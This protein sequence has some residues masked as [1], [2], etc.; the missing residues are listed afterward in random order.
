[1]RTW[2]YHS[3]RRGNSGS[4]IVNAA[5]LASVSSPESNK[6][7]YQRDPKRGKETLRFQLCPYFSEADVVA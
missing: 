2:V 5:W 1:M 4:G 7:L 6:T 3:I